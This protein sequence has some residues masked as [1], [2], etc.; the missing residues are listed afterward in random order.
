V[1]VGDLVR[2]KDKE[3][4]YKW[5]YWTGIVVEVFVPEWETIDIDYIKV[6]WNQDP[7]ESGLIRANLMEVVNESR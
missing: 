2:Y 7:S 4:S 1:K 5:S 3:P 6:I